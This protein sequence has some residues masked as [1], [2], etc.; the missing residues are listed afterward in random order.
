LHISF[1]LRNFAP[2]TTKSRLLSL[3]DTKQKEP[4]CSVGQ[5]HIVTNSITIISRSKKK[6]LGN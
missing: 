6:S 5:K 1:F 4:K 2:Q 3:T